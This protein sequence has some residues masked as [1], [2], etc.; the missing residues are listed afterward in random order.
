MTGP[1][2]PATRPPLHLSWIA[3]LPG[4]AYLSSAPLVLGDQ[5]LVVTGPGVSCLGL[6]DGAARWDVALATRPRELARDTFRCGERVVAR[7]SHARYARWVGLDPA[8]RIVWESTVKG[9]LDVA[10]AD[11]EGLWTLAGGG[12]LPYHLIRIESD[13]GAQRAFDCPFLLSQLHALGPGCL[14]ARHTDRE[15][16]RAGVWRFDLDSGD[17][18]RLVAG[19][20][21]GC[22]V[23]GEHLLALLRVPGE[24]GFAL[25][26]HRVGD[27]APLWRQ[28]GFAGIADLYA[29][30]VL[31]VRQSGATL[32]DARSG[33]EI[34]TLD[35]LGGKAGFCCL[36]E[37]AAI[38]EDGDGLLV[39]PRA[40]PAAATR[41][42][43]PRL[44][45]ITAIGPSGLFDGGLLASAGRAVA[46]W[47][48]R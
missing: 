24:A 4:P 45:L 9:G 21:Q 28:D 23:Y 27:S 10:C 40:E 20:I 38:L 33:A 7:V 3:P 39:I 26:S 31:A 32:L 14:L 37:D 18:T 47:R 30:V 29:G 13:T 25:Q 35:D 46:C 44:A 6:A 34:A 15:G 2:R 36:S 16:P 1:D 22:W 42:S 11:S 48:S 43:D 12:P 19:W 5:A 17:Y 41:A 8:G